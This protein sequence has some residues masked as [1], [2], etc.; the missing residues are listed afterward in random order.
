MK[1]TCLK[2][3]NKLLFLILYCIGTLSLSVKAQTTENPTITA[4]FQ[5]SYRLYKDIRKPNGI[6]LDALALNGV[7]DKPA[8]IVANG[9]GLISLCIADAMYQKTGDQAHWETNAADQVNT[10]LQ[11][12][13][14]FKNAGKTNSAGL[15]YRYFDYNTGDQAWSSEYSTIDNA[16]FAMGI[17]F[18][19]NYFASN[20]SI[21]AKAN[22]ILNAM[23][24]T[25][26][27][28]QNNIYMILDQNGNGSAPT[29]PF[30]EYILVSW[31]AKNAPASHPN[32]AASQ[33]FWNT[34]FAN[35]VSAPVPHVNY[36]GHVTLSDGQYW[37]SSFI[38]QFSYYLCNYYKNNTAYMD[39]F[40]STRKSD[41]L[42]SENIGFSAYEWG[43]GAGDI[44]GGGYSA[45]AVENNP[46]RIVS[47]HIVAGFIPVNPQ[48]KAD[49]LSLY[50]DGTGPAV[51]SLVSDPSKKVLWR[52]RQNSTSLRSS[53]IQ[54]IDF[55]TMLFGLAS[56]PEYLGNNWFNTY[57]VINS[58][59]AVLG[60][61]RSKP[62]ANG[63]ITYNSLEKTIKINTIPGQK[64][65]E[66]YR[67]D[68]RILHQ[69]ST[70][71]THISIEAGAFKQSVVVVLVQTKEGVI[72]KKISVY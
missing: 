42:Y 12:F 19:K 56:L 49:L 30:N 3:G 60:T 31:L 59:S 7:G 8:A 6:Y 2:S 70:S 27:I 24:Y 10:T 5:N 54:A 61:V 39:Y 26:A 40:D 46:Q 25:K 57:N 20:P 62:A 51:Y 28:G 53:Y 41:K 37:L 58:S 33:T 55:S 15:F 44:P 22:T 43:M 47:P 71:D 32:Y 18:C 21:V 45:D 29:S 16:I 63:N 69:I 11:T 52:Y 35:P 36:W 17:I 34:Y 13:I 64:R 4:L 50:N 67:T 48:S 72:K 65:V 66:I 68:G 38:P 1:T 23:D 9:I 14:N